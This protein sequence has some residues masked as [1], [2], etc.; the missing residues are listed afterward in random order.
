MAGRLRNPRSRRVARAP[1]TRELPRRSAFSPPHRCNARR[2]FGSWTAPFPWY[3]APL[4]RS[5]MSGL[6]C[7]PILARCDTASGWYCCQRSRDRGWRSCRRLV[8]TLASP[9]PL[10]PTPTLLTLLLFLDLV[11]CPGELEVELV[12]VSGPSLREGGDGVVRAQLP[13]SCPGWCSRL[14]WAACGVLTVN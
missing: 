3:V 5:R 8:V 7:P 11:H 1:A 4:G 13:F 14:P 6:A 10:I 9:V 12:S 2:S